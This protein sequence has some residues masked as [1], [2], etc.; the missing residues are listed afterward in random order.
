MA[1]AT[2]TIQGSSPKGYDG[3]TLTPLTQ[4]SLG[5]A[6]NVGTNN[7]NM[8][9][10]VVPPTSNV[11]TSDSMKP[12]SP[13][14][15]ADNTVSPNSYTSAINQTVTDLTN[16]VNTAQKNVDTLNTQG[17]ADSKAI[18]DLQSLLGGKVADTAKTYN[19]TGVT[20]IYNQLADLNAQATGLKNESL[21][22]PIQIQ[23]EFKGT[24]ATDAGVKPIE[25][26]RLRDN[27]LKALSLGQ[28]AA[29]ASAQ[30]DK[31]KN[32]ADQIIESKYT[33]IE[34]DIKA[35]QT[36]LQALRDFDLTPAQNKLLKVQE[37]Q[38]QYEAQQLADKKATEKA[39]SSLLVT[40]AQQNAPKAIQDQAR[41]IADNG[42][43]EAEVAAALGLYAGDYW[44]T[45][46]KIAQYNQTVANTN[47]TNAEARAAGSGSSGSF[48]AGI[49]TNSP[50]QSWLAQYNSGAM[51]LEDIYTKIGSSKSAEVTKNEL[52]ALIAAQ[53]G[54][55]VLTMDDTQVSAIN[56]Q[57]K[58]INDLIGTN[59]Y[60]Y[61][62]ISGQSQGGFLGIGAR[63]T[64]AK[65]DALA[66]AQ[67]L[68][69]NQ[70]LQ[71]LADAKAKGITFG[72]LSGPE[73]NTVASAASRISA[74]A[75]VNKDT[76]KITGFSGSQSEF[77]K[78]LEAIKTGLQNS[79]KSKTGLTSLGGSASQKADIADKVINFPDTANNTGGYIFK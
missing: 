50:A 31:A 69:S 34:A 23:N 2:N 72:A 4:G 1:T 65:D 73:L 54:K 12:V 28:Q 19:E 49:T 52:S 5:T 16:S 6:T 71:S 40:A 68:V 42:G 9:S 79:I 21:A 75:I 44:G 25:T 66:M 18:S 27:A 63:I 78:D 37:T 43:S 11:I 48:P 76:G 32:Y 62:V 35:K 36:N 57:I 55:R 15:L 77:K 47:K 30:Y 39:T 8:G 38:L 10:F 14:P 64:G 74:K 17:K 13:V 58:N 22:I 51:S 24:G 7:L 59:G 56:E 33:Q 29:I 60:N 20:T 61:K 3:K 26:S 67:N 45:K 41:K 70:T 46:M 53:G